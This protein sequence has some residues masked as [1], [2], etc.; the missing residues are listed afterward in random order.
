MTDVAVAPASPRGHSLG[1]WGM[2]MLVAAEA[3]LFALM[4]ALA[5]VAWHWHEPEEPEPA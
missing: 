5:A 4:A 3:A 1:W 2:A